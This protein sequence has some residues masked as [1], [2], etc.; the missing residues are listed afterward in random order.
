MYM[1]YGICPLGVV[2][3]RTG[4]NHSSE[5]SSQ[6]L[7]G[8]LFEVMDRQ[9]RQ[10]TKVCCHND[11]YVG[12]VDSKQIQFITPS[13]F[14]RYTHRFAYNLE[15][16][17]PV[18]ANDHCL[19]ITLGAQLPNFDGMRFYIG[20]TAFQ[21]SGQAV[22]P[23]DIRA[24]AEFV[25][26]IARRLLYA[27]FQWGGR[28]PMGIDSAGF[29]QLVFKI[30]GYRF[31]REA[32]EQ[33]YQ[34]KAVDFVEQSQAG[35]LAFFENKAGRITHTGIILPD[36]SIIHAYGQVRI[37]ALDHYGIFNRALKRYTHRLRLIKRILPADTQRQTAQPDAAEAVNRQVE[38]F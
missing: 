4:P 34:G 20:D 13:E 31:P 1:S 16:V 17:Q 10:W 14:E 18:M 24:S 11:H 19:P 27:P 25:I 6:L 36:A 8:E 21:Y 33:L 23:D 9:G 12:W 37:D 28:S 35:D 5:Q 22:F 3:L 32:G 7:F 30:A 29:T 2:P 15:V 38:L 26:K